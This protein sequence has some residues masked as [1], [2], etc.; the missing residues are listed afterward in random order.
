VTAD[1]D[2]FISYT[3]ADQAWAEWIADTLERDGYT[4]V[5]QAWD[6][7]PG[8]VFVQRMHQAV[9]QAERT[10]LVLSAAYLA[11]A[12]ATSEWQAVFAKDPTGQ[13]GLLLPVRVAACQPPG[14][15]GGRIYVDLVGLDEPAAAVRLLEGAKRDR[16]RPAGRV[17]FPGTAATQ[18][19]GEAPRFPGRPPAI[20]NVPPRNPS[21]TGRSDLLRALRQQLAETSSSTVVQIG[22]V[23]GLGGVGK[24]Q[25]AIEY[26]HRFASDYDLVWWVPAEQP[27]AIPGWL[28][29]LGRRLGLPEL[30][31]LDELVVAV[32][33]ELGQRDRWLLVF[34]NA[35]APASLDGVRPPAG[36]GHVLVTSRNPAWGGVGATIRVDVLPRDQAVSFL[37]QRT[38][39]TGEATLEAIAAELG[40]LPLALEQAAAYLDETSTEAGEY[41]D[42]LRERASELLALGAPTSYPGTVATTWTLALERV[43]EEAS[44]ARD[45]LA[46][47]AFLA[48]DDIPRALFTD[49]PEAL[50]GGQLAAVVRDQ[51]AY[52]QVIAALRRYSLVSVVSDTLRVHRLVQAVTRHALATDEQQQWAAA[53]VRLVSAGFPSEAHRPDMWPTAAR[54]LAH[55]LIVTG[56]PAASTTDPRATASLLSR[57]GDYLWGRAEYRQAKLLLECALSTAEA[58]LGPDHPETATSL[59]N[60]ALVLWAQGDL[61][62]ARALH[63]RALSIREAHLGPDHPDTAQSLSNLAVVLRL[64][65]DLGRACTELERALAIYEARLGPDH[66]DTALSL[67]RLATVLRDQGDLDGARA[68]HERALTIREAC[69]GTDHPET[70]WSLNNLAVV[71]H[72]QGDLGRARNLHERALSIRE[73][74]LG[75][76]HPDTALSLR[77]LATVLR[78]QGDLDGARTDLERALAI[79]EA[80]LGPEHPDTARSRQDLAVVVAALENRD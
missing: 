1:K 42:L 13:R 6:F 36:G 51:L 55:A 25:L 78:D 79:Y 5:L 18:P 77:R 61:D 49:H 59:N 7:R 30:P 28:G 66:P 23:H 16:A 39:T 4:T 54:L 22:T 46:L 56:H 67:S 9:E 48:P 8:E 14:L 47:C 58:G 34:D 52:Q 3:G 63:E 24:T 15:L 35:K 29:G 72:A 76:D 62:A 64:Q 60:L 74:G 53:A 73:T 32:F 57:V 31:S 71:L 70:A 21:F 80:R 44:A 69:L 19:T 65:G 75:A 41:L 27:I 20:F 11:S 2:F 40:D 38:G 37:Q 45:L 50:S 43:D 33:D 26:A 12:F 68:L 10:I 17:G